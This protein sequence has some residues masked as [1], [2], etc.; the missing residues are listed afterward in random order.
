MCLLVPPQAQAK[1]DANEQQWR[2][3]RQFIKTLITLCG[4]E[5]SVTRQKKHYDIGD[6]IPTEEKEQYIGGK[7][8]ISIKTN[9]G[10][11]YISL[12]SFQF[13]YF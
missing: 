5:V 1:I 8:V 12:I 11:A 7:Y 2:W 6:E 13:E 10:V 4:A 3:G 9:F